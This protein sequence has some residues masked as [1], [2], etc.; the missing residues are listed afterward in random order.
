MDYSQYPLSSLTSFGPLT[1]TVNSPVHPLCSDPYPSLNARYNIWPGPLLQASQQ[2]WVNS[3]R[4]VGVTSQE[5]LLDHINPLTKD[6]R[7]FFF[8]PV[9]LGTNAKS[10]PITCT[11]LGLA[12]SLDTSLVPSFTPHSRASLGCRRCSCLSIVYLLQRAP[13]WLFSSSSPS[14]LPRQHWHVR[15]VF[16]SCCI[17]IGSQETF[18]F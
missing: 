7:G 13:P 16:L 5:C 6:I 11:L 14:Q 10:L 3:L 15:E 12:P 8:S 2:D 9:A 18:Y 4:V 1:N 17:Q